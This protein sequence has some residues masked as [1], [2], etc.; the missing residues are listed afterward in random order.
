MLL[1]QYALF[2]ALI[3]SIPNEHWENDNNIIVDDFFNGNEIEYSI[4]DDSLAAF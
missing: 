2:W 1:C 3:L 4:I